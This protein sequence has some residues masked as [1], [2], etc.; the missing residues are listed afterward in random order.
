M[1]QA[2]FRKLILRKRPVD[3]VGRRNFQ[4][5][6]ADLQQPKPGQVV[7]EVKYLSMDVAMRGWMLAVHSYVPS[8]RVGDVPR[9]C[10]VGIVVNSRAKHLEV[11]DTVIGQLG[12]Q[13]I[14]TLP[15]KDLVRV[16]VRKIT[17]VTWAGYLGLTSAITGYLG[18]LE[19]G[20]PRKGETVFVS[21][22]SGSVGSVVGQ[23]AKLK[24][25]R[26]VGLAG[27]RANCRRL[28]NEFGFDDC[29]DYRASDLGKQLRKKCSERIDLYF[30]NAGGDVLDTTLDWM[31]PHGRIVLCGSMATRNVTEQKGLMNV[32]SVLI[33]RLSVQG[34]VLFDHECR[35]AEAVKDLTRWHSSGRLRLWSSEDLREGGLVGFSGALADLLAG[36]HDG[37]MVL[38]L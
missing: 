29:I 6:N 8:I 19:I 10:G 17:P 24:G 16:D 35:Y 37:K 4:V 26:V 25:A 21:G 34:F 22:A 30:D 28:I 1:M 32:R 38:Q 2:G 7:V 9:A 14:V 31:A 23:V 18:L 12:V 5:V 27:G 20:K 13:E 11:G 33:D 36:S 15:G 3:D